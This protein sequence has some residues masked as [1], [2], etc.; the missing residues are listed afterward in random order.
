MPTP[1]TPE[2]GTCVIV[3]AG[4]AGAKAAET[5][6]AEGFDGRVVLI[7]E[8]PERPYERPPL[9][10]AHLWGAAD[11]E[12]AFVHH[13]SFY[14]E[15]RIELRTATKVV[16]LL[17]DE[18]TVT[19]AGGERLRY[20][21]LLLATGAAPRRLDLAGAELGGV[22]HLRTLA[23]ADQL[24]DA[25]GRASNV[26]VIGAGWIGSEVAAAAR[27]L[28][29]TVAMIAP[30]TVPLQRVLGTE[31]GA[32]YRNLHA[33]HGVDLHLETAVTA[34]R[35]NGHVEEVHLT[36][37]SRV[38]ADLVVVAIGAVPRTELAAAAG[39]AVDDGIVVDA[40]LRTS[41][42][43]IFAA[44]DVAS[45][46]HPH[47]D[48][49]VRVEHWANA[50]H[51]G[52]AAARNMLGIPTP[53]ARIPYFFSDQYDLGMEYSGYAPTWDRVVF[54]GDPTAGEFIAFWLSQDVVVAGMNAN[55][56]DV[57]DT[58]QRLIRARIVVDPDHLA[59]LDTPLEALAETMH[60]AV[61]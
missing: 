50:L 55:I 61:G 2:P 23:D 48:A 47:L 5:L 56:W 9:S 46:F 52:P 4:L 58:I 35:G 18:H 31:V 25:I 45:A 59:D 7:G 51:Q 19:L 16:A 60:P 11:R 29:R 21:R 44:G 20:D 30:A 3:G 6:R 10:K 13:E 8:E 54:R 38:A 27:Q 57:S 53:Y 12:K 34:L 42:P 1:Q 36:G 26:A 28:G 17:P 40:H 14:A 22:H 24:A 32:V 41:A 49:R 43:D 15:Q 37:G 33:D 39:L